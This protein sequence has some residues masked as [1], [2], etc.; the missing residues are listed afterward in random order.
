MPSKRLLNAIT[1]PA[2]LATLLER[3]KGQRPLLAM[4]IQRTRIG[5]A[6]VWSPHSDEDVE[7][8]PDVLVPNRRIAPEN[9]SSLA[10]TMRSNDVCGVL[11]NWPVQSYSGKMGGPCGRVLFTLE[12]M[13]GEEPASTTSSHAR[14]TTRPLL[15]A[16]RPVALWTPPPP[17]Q[18]VP[19]GSSSPPPLEAHQ[20]DSWGR[21]VVYSQAS[22]KT[23]HRASKEQYAF[24]ETEQATDLWDDFWKTNWPDWHKR[25][26]N[27]RRLNTSSVGQ[28]NLIKDW[29][30]T[31]AP[32]YLAT[33]AVLG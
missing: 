20:E 24:D 15:C 7:P 23:V 29:R 19:P 3:G 5:L 12:S 10:Y 13:L 22:N 26:H 2:R 14:S 27:Q 31:T 16:N 8:L 28:C 18:S 33:Q 32:T 11:V 1:T 4:V 6:M 9:L 25:C 30:E 21:S 17:P